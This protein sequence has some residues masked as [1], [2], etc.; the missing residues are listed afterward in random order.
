MPQARGAPA[1]LPL[2]AVAFSN[3][4][5]SSDERLDGRG[6]AQAVVAALTVAVVDRGHNDSRRAPCGKPNAAVPLLERP[7]HVALGCVGH[8]ELACATVCSC[9]VACMGA[10]TKPGHTM[11]ITIVTFVVAVCSWRL[12]GGCQAIH[13]RP[14]SRRS[15]TTDP[16]RRRS[17]GR[18]PA[19]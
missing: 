2:R 14:G 11:G 5:G 18:A 19:T 17:R 12:C 16:G 8:V 13:M 10:W 4:S 9:I 7:W 3:H 1:M 6:C 15:G